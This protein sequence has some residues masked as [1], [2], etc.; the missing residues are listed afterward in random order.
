MLSDILDILIA[1]YQEIYNKQTNISLTETKNQRC[2]ML[3]PRKFNI[4]F[5]LM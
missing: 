2:F 5:M 3:H 1:H 4:K